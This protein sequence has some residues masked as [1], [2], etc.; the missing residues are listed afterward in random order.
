MREFSDHN[1]DILVATS[2]I[3]V[4]V[5]VPN[6]TMIII[7]G[8]ERYGLAQ[9]HQLR[10]RVLRGTH[11]AYCYLFT[12]GATA[13]TTNERLGAFLKAKNGF[14]LAEY[15]LALRGAGSLIG[16][17]QWGMSDLAMEALKNPKL[18]EFARTEARN[19]I[20]QDPTLES[21]PDLETHLKKAV[22]FE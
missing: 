15:D 7:E 9:L 4:G 5:N 12:T 18:V 13:D 17:K 8:A 21:W 1:L 6:S 3:E 22:H 2:V 11:Q 16:N 10:G 20:S 14:E 19:I